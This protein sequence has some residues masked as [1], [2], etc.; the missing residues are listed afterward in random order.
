MPVPEPVVTVTPDIPVGRPL[1]VRT[2]AFELP[3]ELATETVSVNP[4][5]PAV[6][7]FADGV[8]VVLSTCA[9]APNGN[10][11]SALNSKKA[12]QRLGANRCN[13][14]EEINGEGGIDR[15]ITKKTEKF[16]KP[17]KAVTRMLAHKLAALLVRR[18]AAKFGINYYSTMTHFAEIGFYVF[19]RHYYGGEA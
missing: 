3:P 12:R 17:T 18:Y 4:A 9:H 11:K 15:T 6:T 7:G 10:V 2:T 8:I 5:V 19:E 16:K 13:Q 1:N 14:D